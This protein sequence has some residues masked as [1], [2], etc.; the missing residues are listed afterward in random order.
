MLDLVAPVA[1]VLA[2][3][4]I[5]VDMVRAAMAAITTGWDEEQEEEAL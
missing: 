2:A 5:G 3:T 1:V 4:A